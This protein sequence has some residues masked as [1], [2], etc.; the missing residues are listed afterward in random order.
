MTVPFNVDEPITALANL[1]LHTH[2]DPDS[3]Q[4]FFDR[5]VPQ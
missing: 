1:L 2:V 5:V 4:I 3:F